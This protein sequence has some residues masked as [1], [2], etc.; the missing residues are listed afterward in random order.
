MKK[1][2]IVKKVNPIDIY[3]TIDRKSVTGPLRPAQKEI[4]DTWFNSR[5]NDKDLIVKLHTGEGKTLV[6]LLI[7]QSV[8]NSNDGPCIYVCPNKYLVQ[9]VCDEAEK[10]GINYCVFSDD[11]GIPDDYL[12]G[13]K[14]LITHAHK[15]FNGLSVFGMGNRYQKVGTIV[16]DDS[17]ACI[18]IIKDAFSITI[19]KTKNESLYNTILSLF[20][21]DLREQGEG[22]FLD[23]Q[24]GSYDTLLTVPYWT[25]YDKK[26][27]IL[28]ILS[29][30]NDNN[31]I[32]F[33]WPLLKDSIEN[34]NCYITGDKIEIS[35]YSPNVNSF[36]T[37][38][39]A[40]KRILM[41]ATTQDD[42]FFI[43]GLDFDVDAVKKPLIYSEQKWSGEKMLIL[44]SLINE[45]CDRDL[46]VT[47]FAKLKPAKLGIVALVPSTKRA[48]HYQ[49]LGAT[50]SNQNN[51]FEELDKLKN[52]EFGEVLV[53]NNRY[54]GIDLPD[55]SCRILIIDSLPFF[56][57]LSDRYEEQ[58]RASS[59]I[60]NKK[61]AQ[62]VEQG[63]GRGV[64]GE[65]DFC[66]I[67]ITGSDIVRF[68]RSKSTNKFFSAQTQRQIEIGLSIADMGKEDLEE[69]DSDDPLD[70]VMSLIKQSITRDEGWKEY[71]VSEMDTLS[72][73]DDESSLYDKLLS[74]KDIEKLFLEGEYDKAAEK[75]QKFIDS[76]QD[77]DTEKAWYRQQLARFYYKTDILKSNRIQI[78]AFKSNNQLLKP[79]NGITYN[80]LSYVNETRLN[81]VK[82]FLTKYRN[83]EELLLAVDEYL[84]NLSFG[85]DSNKFEDALQEIGELL[86]F[87]SQRPDKDIRKGPDNLWCGVNN[88]YFMFECKNEVVDTRGEINKQE[89]GQMNSHCAWFE[90]EYGENEKISR[91]LIIPTK[92]LSYY[93]N[94]T[95]QVKII[96]KNKLR[97]LK[98]NVKSF[99]RSLHSYNLE[100]ISDETLLKLLN[101]YHLD[102]EDLKNQYSEN[103]YHKT[104]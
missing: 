74:E 91:F 69:K 14:I 3:E 26:T 73:D 87:I 103:Y 59:E 60:I 45:A 46:I 48:Q 104:K 65:K 20:E 17:H 67:I 49:K 83:Y 53:I 64:R 37:F 55:E 47:K 28:T 18:D 19:E 78:S 36:P 11:G 75:M 27:E 85:V 38:A 33:S 51:I 50:V 9:Q 98:Q 61:I 42:S 68:I 31:Q 23:V 56:D 102:I 81:R 99:I 101:E 7:L 13:D 21:E 30:N 76:L 41:S 4:L 43:K 24:N 77:D 34:Y 2:Q 12:S 86:G 94:F 15:I 10:F 97:K 52:N 44:P 93:A 40:N 63:L 80:K 95:H 8:L 6:G 89:A 71:Y 92:D 58:C 22:S 66:A 79:K 29:K 90:K 39:N 32:K 82:L 96:R 1:K 16:L 100:D 70:I 35:P 54:D 84:D 25:W 88:H 5:K 57:S 62:K 72:Y